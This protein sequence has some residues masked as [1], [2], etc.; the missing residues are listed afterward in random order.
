[1]YLYGRL[2]QAEAHELAVFVEAL[3]PHR[4]ALHDRLWTAVTNPGKDKEGQRLC[5]ACA[6]AAYDPGDARWAEVN[7]P[8]A[9]QLVA[10][11]PVFLGPFTAALSPVRSRL[12]DP[13]KAIYGDRRA[14][15]AAERSV[16][17]S[18][19]ATYAA[20]RPSD[21]A[22]LVSDADEKQYALLFPRLQAHAEGAVA[23]LHRELDKKLRHQWDDAP[24]DPSWKEPDRELVEK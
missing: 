16:A 18:L 8:L 11:N 15:R 22:D 19:L 14:E 20:D 24:L 3:R 1:D 5:A 7:A 10:V 13:L 21:L 4:E 17:T 2:L 23:L 6:L 9:A 12:L